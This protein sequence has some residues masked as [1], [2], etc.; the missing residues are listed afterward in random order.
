MSLGTRRGPAGGRISRP[1]SWSDARSWASQA[2]GGRPR[3]IAKR[4]PPLPLG[5][6]GAKGTGG[7]DPGAMDWDGALGDDSDGD[8]DGDGDSKELENAK[9]E[10][11]KLVDRC[12]A[13]QYLLRSNSENAERQ[14]AFYL[15]TLK[16]NSRLSGDEPFVPA[17]LVEEDLEQA[18]SGRYQN[19]MILKRTLFIGCRAK[20]AGPCTTHYKIGINKMSKGGLMS[21]RSV[22]AVMTNH[23]NEEHRVGFLVV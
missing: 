2:S 12:G 1:L 17:D 19:N 21:L 10:L 8:S 11:R 7:A 23:I 22:E 16:G 15:A 4:A 20:H 5:G 6:G 3:A 9:S 13:E 14:P 18:S